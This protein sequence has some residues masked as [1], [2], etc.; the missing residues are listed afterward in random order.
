MQD[1]TLMQNEMPSFKAQNFYL[2]YNEPIWATY[3]TEN[4]TDSTRS[5][6]VSVPNH[7]YKSLLCGVL[8]FTAAAM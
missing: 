4:G 3:E 2:I 5:V 1:F 7:V 8:F 6:P